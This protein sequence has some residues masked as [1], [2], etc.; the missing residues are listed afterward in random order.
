MRTLGKIRFC[1]WITNLGR[2]RSWWEDDVYECFEL[3]YAVFVL[4]TACVILGGYEQM[5]RLLRNNIKSE[6]SIWSKERQNCAPQY[7]RT[8][9]QHTT[10]FTYQLRLVAVCLLTWTF[11]IMVCLLTTFQE[12]TAFC[13]VPSSILLL[14]SWETHPF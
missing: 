2:Q 14:D 11:V 9:I 6:L 3:Q 13:F 5:N 4:N 8:H 12:E 1:I 7:A 10:K